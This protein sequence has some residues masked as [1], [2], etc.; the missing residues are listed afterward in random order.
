MHRPS[1]HCTFDSISSWLKLAIY[2]MPYVC[3]ISLCLLLKPWRRITMLPVSDWA[4]E[5]PEYKKH[6]Q[7]QFQCSNSMLH[8]EEWSKWTLLAK[9]VKLSK[10]LVVGVFNSKHS[11]EASLLHSK[12]TTWVFCPCYRSNECKAW[13][14]NS[15]L[16]QLYYTDAT[17]QMCPICSFINKYLGLIISRWLYI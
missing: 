2:L 12:M 11:L 14:H 3:S 7:M 8:K 17:F 4:V 13:K 5:S 10:C 15:G 6:F 9:D 1:A 16:I